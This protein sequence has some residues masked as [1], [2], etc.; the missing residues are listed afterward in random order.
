LHGLPKADRHGVSRGHPK[1]A[2]DIRAEDRVADDLHQD[3]IKRAQ[4]FHAF[5]P[6]CGTPI[7]A[8]SPESSIF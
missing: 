2:G 6:E 1:P 7:Y 4:R 3:W 8:T 5:C